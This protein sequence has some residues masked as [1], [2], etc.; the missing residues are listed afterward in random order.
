V[1]SLRFR[2]WKHC[3]GLAPAAS[4]LAAAAKL[5]APAVVALACQIPLALADGGTQVTLVGMFPNKA[6]L[7]IGNGGPRAVAVGQALE[8]VTLMSVDD[9]SAVVEIDGKRR[10][11]KMGQHYAATS[12]E[13]DK[14]VLSADH[15]GHFYADARVNGKLLRLLVDTGATLVAIPARDAERMGLH[16]EDGARITISTANG[17][18]SAYK[19]KLDTISIGG[20]TMTDVDAVVPDTGLSMPLLGMSFLSR[21]NMQREGDMMTLTKRF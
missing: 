20:I 7:V 19:V 16:Y 8:G 21:T 5:L 10:T 6:V 1:I 12:S 15:G 3:K 4:C 14:I 18:S 17:V 11:L 2:C 9:D 13:D